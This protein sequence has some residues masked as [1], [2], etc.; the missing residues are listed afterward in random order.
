LTT[1]SVE[2]FDKF[3]LSQNDLSICS[4]ATNAMFLLL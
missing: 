4:T 2:H 1:D 3:F